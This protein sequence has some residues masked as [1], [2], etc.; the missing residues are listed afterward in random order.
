MPSR[1]IPHRSY[2]LRTLVSLLLG[3]TALVLALQFGPAAKAAPAS[4]RATN[5]NVAI[6]DFAF[7]PAVITITEGSSVEWTNTSQFTPHTTTSND[8]LWDRTLGPGDVVSNTFAAPGT[9][10]YHCAI[11]SFMTGSV[12]VVTFIYLPLIMRT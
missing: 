7:E 1:Q 3:V 2:R 4:A 12:V 8:L 9:Y 5:G 6:V 11:H 10:A